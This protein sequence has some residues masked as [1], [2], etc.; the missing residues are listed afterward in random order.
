VNSA[1][2]RVLAVFPF[3]VNVQIPPGTLPG[4]ATV[5]VASGNGSAEQPIAIREVAPVIFL[6]GEGQAAITNQDNQLNTAS[7]PASRGSSIVIYATGGGAT[8]ASG[9]LT[10]VRTPLTVNAGGADL[11]PFF[12]GLTPSAIGLYQVNVVLPAG[13]TPGLAQ[14]LYLKQGSVT[15]NVV[16]VAIQ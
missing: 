15:S 2:A 4:T 7:N 9:S 16:T 10:A 8:V 14:Q 1:S 6:V 3:Q 11:T 5:S 12:A 13:L